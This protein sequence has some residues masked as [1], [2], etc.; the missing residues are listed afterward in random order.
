MDK[1]RNMQPATERGK[2]T[3]GKRQ[4]VT[5]WEKAT[6]EKSHR[7]GKSHSGEKVKMS[8][9]NAINMELKII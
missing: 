6:V 2:A 4:P 1:D 9:G 3:V 5:E 8:S 7:A